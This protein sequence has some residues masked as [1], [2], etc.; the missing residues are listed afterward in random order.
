MTTAAIGYDADMD[1][2]RL[3]VAAQVAEARIRLGLS[4]PAV[5]K[6]AGVNKSTVS[7]LEAGRNVNSTSLFRIADALGLDGKVLFVQRQQL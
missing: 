3:S 7:A 2:A 4:I 6:L 1:A 5:A